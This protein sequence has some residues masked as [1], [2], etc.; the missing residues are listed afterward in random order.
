MVLIITILGVLGITFAFR[1]WGLASLYT[2]VVLGGII[3]IAGER[4]RNKSK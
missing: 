2:G 3:G 1:D 4:N